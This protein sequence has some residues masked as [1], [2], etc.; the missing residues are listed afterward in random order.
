M[1][2]QVSPTGEVAGH[3]L[4]RVVSGDV[5]LDAEP[6]FVMIVSLGPEVP[7]IVTFDQLLGPA[8]RA[9]QYA[10]AELAPTEPK[11]PA[12]LDRLRKHFPDALARAALDT[13]MLRPKARAKFDRADR[14]YFSREALEMATSEAVARYRAGRF[15]PFPLHRY[16]PKRI[17]GAGGFGTAVLC[18][19]RNFAEDVVVVFAR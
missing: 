14:M 6:T 7:V 16:E 12:C 10:A 18:H 2:T 9:A 4:A 19:D 15:A 17:L 13:I 5:R 3:V 1:L 8:G 11:Y